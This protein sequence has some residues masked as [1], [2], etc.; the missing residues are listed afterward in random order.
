M[1]QVTHRPDARSTALLLAALL[2]GGMIARAQGP[3]IGYIYPAG[4]RQGTTVEATVGGQYISG[5]SEVYISGKGIHAEVLRYTRAISQ[6][7]INDLRDKQREMSQSDGLLKYRASEQFEQM[8]MQAGIMDPSSDGFSALQR[9]LNDPKRQPNAQ[10]GETV[11][12]RITFDADAEVGK[13]EMRLKSAEGYTNPIYFDVGQCREYTENE[14]NDR[15]PDSKVLHVYMADLDIWVD[16]EL[17]VILNGQI[18][19]G[20]VDRF[21]FEAKKGTHLVAAV[22]ARRLVPYLADAVPGWFQA[23]LAFLDAKGRELAF[24]DDYRFDPD[25]VI[26]CEVPADGEYVLQIEDSISRGRED[27]VYRIELGELPYL[28]GIFPLGGQAGKETTVKLEGW[29]LP[30]DKMTL[31]AKGDKPGAVPVSVT[32][33]ARVSNRLLFAVDTLPEALEVE[34]NNDQ[35]R[36]QKVELPIIVNGRISAPGDWDVFSFEGHKGDQFAAEI[37]ARRLRSPL[38]SIV[39]LTGPS[40]KLVAANDDYA[41]YNLDF[42]VAEDRGSGL[43][44]H[45]ADSHFIA[46]LPADGTYLVHVGDTQHKGGSAYGYRLRIGPP[47]PDF[48]L[49]AVPSTIHA[50]PGETVPIAVHTIRSDGFDGEIELALKDMPKGFTLRGRGI[51]ADQDHVRLTLTVP[52]TPQRKPVELKVEGRATVAGEQ[53]LRTATPTEDVMQAFLWRHLVPTEDGMVTVAGNRMPGPPLQAQTDEA[54]MLSAG[55][56]V[57]LR[58][59]GCETEKAKNIRVEL[60]QPPKGISIKE[61]KPV[62]QGLSVVLSTDAAAAKAGLKG[63][64]IFNVDEETIQLDAE[65]NPIG[66]PRRTSLGVL[67]AVPFEII[68]TNAVAEA[69]NTASLE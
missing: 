23:T 12:L 24:S 37:H 50:Q 20:D 28:T 46:E 68:G 41:A 18:M 15:D 16:E 64:L 13:R 53:V 47:R 26:C 62:E 69:V 6:G 48:L 30:V 29:N 63:N 55:E 14:P 49:R 7:T 54:M 21:R 60:N 19:P 10:L 40:G 34:P 9:S 51:P 52:I 45:H 42:I 57:E 39:K 56:T 43:N 31:R 1:T 38:D 32:K 66:S 58:V 22:S 3:H 65:G 11:K 25:P 17:P 67:P 33:G 59:V 36:A 27:F 35:A 61:V 5:V 2:A 44:T 4:G 8:A